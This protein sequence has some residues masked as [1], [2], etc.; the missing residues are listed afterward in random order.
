MQNNLMKITR[1]SRFLKSLATINGFLT[2]LYIDN[3]INSDEQK[4]LENWIIENMELSKSNPFKEIFPILINISKESEDIEEKIKDVRWVCENYL[5]N[6]NYLNKIKSDMQ[7]LHGII[8]GI[9]ADYKINIVEVHE[10]KNWIQ[11]NS[12]LKGVW[13][14]DELESILLT[15]L[16]DQKL[17]VQEE[18]TLNELFYEFANID[19]SKTITN[20]TALINKKLT[21]VCAVDPIMEVKNKLFCFTGESS[22]YERSDFKKI[23]EKLGGVVKNSV[24]VNL[25]YLIV[26]AKGSDYW[27]FNCYGRKV[28]EAVMLRKKGSSLQI[29]HEIDFLDNLENYK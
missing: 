26:C 13:P 20:P 17:T 12:Q 24:V 15:V 23:I 11:D 19:D 29:I 21:G 9:L 16:K 1:T 2:G 6:E 8:S 28:E 27:A 5:S 25:D 18:E 3:E 10:L 22:K 4:A 7:M 14:Y